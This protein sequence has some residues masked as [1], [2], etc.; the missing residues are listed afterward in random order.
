MAIN[1]EWLYPIGNTGKLYA[2]SKSNE[3]NERK[4][5]NN[6]LLKILDEWSDPAFFAS[7][8]RSKGVFFRISDFY[9]DKLKLSQA[10]SLHF[11]FRQ[12][13]LK[14]LRQQTLSGQKEDLYT[15]FLKNSDSQPMGC[16]GSGKLKIKLKLA[17]QT[18]KHSWLRLYAVRIPGGKIVITGGAIKLLGSLK[19]Q[20]GLLKRV[21]RVDQY[22][23]ELLEKVPSDAIFQTVDIRDDAFID[24]VNSWEEYVRREMRES[25]KKRRSFVLAAELHQY[26]H[27]NEITSADLAKR[28]VMELDDLKALLKGKLP[29]TEGEAL[30]VR[31]RLKL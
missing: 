30:L 26:M 11:N 1:R 16:R 15:L 20:S 24:A 17:P 7:F 27:T 29:T 12:R 2:Y 22:G 31:T 8:Y 18:N 25:A 14:V 9:G 21:N 23:D 6:E 28:L 3:G 5:H 13:L 10:A 19:N 4:F